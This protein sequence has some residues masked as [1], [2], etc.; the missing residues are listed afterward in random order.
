MLVIGGEALNLNRAAEIDAW[1]TLEEL[2]TLHRRLD[3]SFLRQQSFPERW[4]LSRPSRIG[5]VFLDYEVL[6]DALIALVSA[7]P[8]NTE[9]RIY[10][11]MDVLVA[12]K[13]TCCLIKL[14]AIE[15]V[16]DAKPKHRS[17]L[18]TLWPR[19]LMAAIQAGEAH[20]AL[21]LGLRSHLAER[22][23]HNNNR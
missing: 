19:G 1:G 18:A 21:F 4:T 20:E 11:S 23:R 8:D 2:H 16:P 3:R 17:D 7:L 13:L 12:S 14:A 5:R 22:Y 6:S 10:G 15:T 9:G